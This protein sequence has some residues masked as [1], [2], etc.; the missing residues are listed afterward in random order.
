MLSIVYKDVV[1]GACAEPYRSGSAWF[2]TGHLLFDNAA[3]V[4]TGF[5]MPMVYE[6]G[7]FSQDSFD[8]AADGVVRYSDCSFYAY[9]SHRPESGDTTLFENA[10]IRHAKV[11]PAPPAGG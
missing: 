1:I 10:C 9:A 2:D 3:V 8:L 11:D 7:F 5:R 6:H 4:K